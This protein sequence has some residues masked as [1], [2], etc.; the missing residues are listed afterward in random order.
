M[1]QKKSTEL[2][3]MLLQLLWHDPY[4]P[5]LFKKAMSCDETEDWIGGC[6]KELQNFKQRSVYQVIK[7][8]EME[9]GKEILGTG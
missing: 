1:R 8:S 7:R 3:N 9:E 5:K 6:L 2:L 4:E